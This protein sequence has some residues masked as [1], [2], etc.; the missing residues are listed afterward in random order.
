[1]L[2]RRRQTPEAAPLTVEERAELAA[3]ERADGQ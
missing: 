3:L 1:M 2:Y